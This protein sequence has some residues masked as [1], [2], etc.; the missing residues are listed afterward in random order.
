MRAAVPIA[1]DAFWPWQLSSAARIVRYVYTRKHSYEMKE[2]IGDVFVANL[3][4]FILL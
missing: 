3:F 1:W 2:S 4:G